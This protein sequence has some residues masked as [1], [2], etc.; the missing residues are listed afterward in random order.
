MVTVG[1]FK[2]DSTLNLIAFNK[3][4]RL[5]EGRSC[6][7]IGIGGPRIM[8]KQSVTVSYGSFSLTVEGYDDPFG[9]IREI[10]ELYAKMSSLYPGFGAEPM[11]TKVDNPTPTTTTE[12]IAAVSEHPEPKPVEPMTLVSETALD[13]LSLEEPEPEPLQL[14]TPLPQYRRIDLSQI[15]AAARPLST[16]ELRVLDPN[17]KQFPANGEH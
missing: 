2:T 11:Q 13:D 17:V 5:K 3:L 14:E 4:K 7:R 15:R 6:V 9:V 1:P 12:P 10:T 16:S 8:N